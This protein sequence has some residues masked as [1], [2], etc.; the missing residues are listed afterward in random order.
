MQ[1]NFPGVEKIFCVFSIRY[2]NYNYYIKSG[3]LILKKK[4]FS[5]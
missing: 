4:V 5:F 3:N 1:S 2:D